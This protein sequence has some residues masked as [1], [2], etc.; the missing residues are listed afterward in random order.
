MSLFDQ[1]KKPSQLSPVFQKPKRLKGHLKSKNRKGYISPKLN[2][3]VKESPIKLKNHRGL[4]KR[5]KIVIIIL[6]RLVQDGIEDLK[7]YTRKIII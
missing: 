3:K 1:P 5:I 6:C 4:L 2:T 7:D